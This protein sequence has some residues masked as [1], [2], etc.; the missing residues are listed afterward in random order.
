MQPMEWT[1]ETL[2]N[3][4]GLQ[5]GIA[6]GTASITQATSHLVRFRQAV[7]VPLAFAN[8]GCKMQTVLS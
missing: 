6:M 5:I 4:H 1:T 8:G 3:L 7:G 2:A